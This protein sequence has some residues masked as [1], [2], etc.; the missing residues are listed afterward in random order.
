MVMHDGDK[1]T[2]D[3]DG[4]MLMMNVRVM[5]G[6]RNDFCFKG[7]ELQKHLIDG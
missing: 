1:N 5:N 4:Y 2:D 6:S 3:D 7:L